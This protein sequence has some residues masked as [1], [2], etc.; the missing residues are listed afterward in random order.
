M[1]DLPPMGWNE[2]AAPEGVATVKE[3]LL[4]AGKAALFAAA[5]PH[6]VG[7]GAGKTVILHEAP[8]TVLGR[9]LAAQNQPRGTC[10]SRGAKRTCDLQ[11]FVQIVAGEPLEVPDTEAKLVSHA[12]IYG[13]CREHGGDL[14]YQDG[15]VGAWAAWSVAHD[16]LLLN[17]DVQDGDN[18]DNL[19]VEWGARGVPSK[20]KEQG[21]KHLVKNVAQIT[22]AADARDALIARKGVTIA[23]NQGFEPF[24]RDAG[25]RCKPGG[26]WAHQ[27]CFTGYRDD[28][29]WFLVDQSWGPNQP[30]GPLGDIEIPSYGF[31]IEWEV[32]EQMIRQGDCWA[33]DAVGAWE[34]Q[35]MRWLV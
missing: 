23:S 27:M 25:G 35:E 21:R 2:Q 11:I 31:W 1:S 24:R 34:S 14:S 13:T 12:Y 22:S 3:K 9:F 15:A 28:L 16:G 4:R 33:F 17:G 7:T 6:L 10:V 20:F 32:A 18:Q 26:R 30:S 29:K 8:K 5:A 19:A